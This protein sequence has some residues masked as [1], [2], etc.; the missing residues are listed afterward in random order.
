MKGK[1]IKV[2]G[3]AVR[4]E[5]RGKKGLYTAS[6]R[7]EGRQLS[8]GLETTIGSIAETRAKAWAAAVLGEKWE[9]LSAVQSARE[10]PTL[11]ALV[12]VLTG[13]AMK[14]ERT[15]REYAS[16]LLRI[17]YVGLGLRDAEEA[18]GV[19]VSTLSA[20]VCDRF[21]AVK[22]GLPGPDYS[23]RIRPGNNAINSTLRNGKAAFG[24]KLLRAY[25]SAGLV[26]R[27]EWLEPLL[28]APMVAAEPTDFVMPSEA[29][30][31]D[32]LRA[33]AECERDG[34][35]DLFLTTQLMLCLGMD[36]KEVL[37]CRGSWL[38]DGV[39][40]LKAR[41]EEGFQGKT[42]NRARCLSVPEHLLPYL[43]A[44]GD[45]YVVMPEGTKTDRWNLIYREHSEWL[46]TW[47]PAD[48]YTKS[49]HSLRKLG[50]TLVARREGSARAG[51]S[52]LGNLEATF[53]RHYDGGSVE[54]GLDLREIGRD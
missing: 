4:V 8:K 18:R 11:G 43:L 37:H 49:N 41:P 9:A 19:R 5:T 21:V 33:S 24:G 6:M 30:I 28:S 38:A 44:A 12:D 40:V 35:V 29:V 14:A 47:F 52:F 48:R 1:S 42:L 17:G 51:A 25:E 15:Q 39:L 16:S 54:R 45:N 13:G 46:R 27:R 50:G 26:L 23:T 34:R 32:L 31:G 53:Q 2:Q 20:S 7:H 3:R 22:Q 36:A 10:V